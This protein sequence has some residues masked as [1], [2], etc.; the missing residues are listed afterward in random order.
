MQAR[1]RL[2]LDVTATANTILNTGIDR[3]A[4]SL[5][6]ALI[7]NEA[8]TLRAEPVYLDCVDGTWHYRYARSFTLELLDCDP[9]YYIVYEWKDRDVKKAGRY[10][11][12]FTITFLDGSGKLI[13]PTREELFINILD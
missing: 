13:T 10:K 12:Q 4:R 1:L 5:V 11:G 2:F 7:K 3:S 8:A 6:T 9:E